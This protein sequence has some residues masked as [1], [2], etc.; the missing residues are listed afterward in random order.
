M[1]W[2][3]KNTHIWS[4][5][6][7]HQNIWVT[8]MYKILRISGLRLE[9]FQV[10]IYK[11][12]NLRIAYLEYFKFFPNFFQ[13]STA[14]PFIATVEPLSTHA[15]VSNQQ[16]RPPLACVGYFILDWN[17]KLKEDSLLLY[18]QSKPRQETRLREPVTLFLCKSAGMT[19]IN[20]YWEWQL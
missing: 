10:G 5:L 13:R 16:W 1:N 18:Q 4:L 9:R 11:F 7:K 14:C 12:G 19:F 15:L 3:Q 8:R 6:I 20:E 17:L 2:Y